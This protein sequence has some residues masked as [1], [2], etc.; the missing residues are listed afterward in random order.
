M[1]YNF[2]Y[3]FCI[4]EYDDKLVEMLENYNNPKESFNSKVIMNEIGHIFYRIEKLGGITLK[5]V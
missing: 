5:W 2:E 4:P 3:D 1:V